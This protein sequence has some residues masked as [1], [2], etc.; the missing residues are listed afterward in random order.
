MI[1][2]KTVNQPSPSS[3]TIN[4]GH[5]C[6]AL[7]HVVQ[8]LTPHILR[9]KVVPLGLHCRSLAHS[10]LESFQPGNALKDSHDLNCLFQKFDIRVPSCC[11]RPEILK[12][13]RVLVHVIQGTVEPV[14]EVHLVCIVRVAGAL[15]EEKCLQRMKGFSGQNSLLTLCCKTLTSGEE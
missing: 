10:H 5:S 9:Y 15:L 13:G 14:F 1:L 2:W 8:N 3:I 11:H 4:K 7:R 12:D 6:L